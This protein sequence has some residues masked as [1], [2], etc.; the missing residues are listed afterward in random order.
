MR[1]KK[2]DAYRSLVSPK[3]ARDLLD[4]YYLQMRSALLETAAAFDRIERARGGREISEDKR[5]KDLM[6]VCSIITGGSK[7]RAEKILS[8]LSDPV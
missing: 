1:M 2:T 8:L 4:M 5:Y 6:E 3:P 7:D